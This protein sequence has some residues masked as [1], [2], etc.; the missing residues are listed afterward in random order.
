MYYFTNNPIKFLQDFKIHYMTFSKHLTKGTY[1]LGRYLFSRN[2]E[3]TARYKL[4]TLSELVLIIENIRE[5]K[6][7]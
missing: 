1:Y 3:P 4:M 2:L 7:N 6:K 5:S